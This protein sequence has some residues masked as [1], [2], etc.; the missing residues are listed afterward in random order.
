MSRCRQGRV[1]RHV[2][3]LLVGLTIVAVAIGFCSSA[4]ASVYDWT[5]TDN[6]VSGSGTLITGA[7]SGGGFII[8]GI[9]GTFDG[10]T[11]TGLGGGFL[12]DDTLF[13]SAPLLS[14]DGLAFHATIE[15]VPSTVE[16]FF[17]D[18][19]QSFTSQ[20]G[21]GFTS[22][23]Q[24]L[25]F[26]NDPDSCAAAGN[27]IEGIDL[28]ARFDSDLAGQFEVVSATPLPGALP[29][30]GSVLGAAYIIR[31]RRRN[32]ATASDPKQ[33]AESAE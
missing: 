7:A 23:L 30:M 27:R 24:S 32:C 31:R 19:Q 3:P 9:T 16:F 8:T 5:Y 21:Y 33:L 6:G 17:L 12:A 25:E 26:C 4:R 2:S 13:S 14:F 1:L 11:I 22:Y 10:G 29:L 15:G 20:A 28:N 18:Q